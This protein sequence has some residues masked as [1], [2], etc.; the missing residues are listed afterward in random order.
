MMVHCISAY[1]E[2]LSLN[3]SRKVV[4]TTSRRCSSSWLAWP[5]LLCRRLLSL[6]A[7]PP[8]HTNSHSHELLYPLVVIV[9]TSP[10]PS[11]LAWSEIA[12]GPTTLLVYEA[13][14]VVGNLARGPTIASSLDV[15]VDR[16]A[17]TG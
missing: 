8:L 14:V 13:D 17:G 3:L 2:V 12:H 11:P 16:D 10:P 9:L 15:N 7:F 5:E 6:P 4:V 1:S